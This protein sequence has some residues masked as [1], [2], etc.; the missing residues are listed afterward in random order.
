MSFPA[1][2]LPG[3]QGEEAASELVLRDR[4]APGLANPR[5]PKDIRESSHLGDSV[6]AV[7]EMLQPSLR[8]CV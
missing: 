2:V 1:V 6:L 5:S 7:P 8:G 3:N 4:A